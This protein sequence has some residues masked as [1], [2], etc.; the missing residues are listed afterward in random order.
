V[1]QRRDLTREETAADTQEIL[2]GEATPVHE[3]AFLVALSM[4]GETE[5]ELLGV[6]SVLRGKTY[7]FNQ[8]G[9]IEVGLSSSEHR[10]LLASRAAEGRGASQD[11]AGGTFN[12][13]TAVALTVAGAG[14]KVL[15]QGYRSQ[16][17]GLESSG[18]LE[19]LGINTEIPA[20]KIDKGVAEVGVGFVFE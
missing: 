5:A 15:Q 8:H 16:D 7:Y 14:V 13:S 2:S 9:P 17:W 20:W 4:K 12:F 18:V 6:A 3:A 19:A 1:L 11:G 10:L